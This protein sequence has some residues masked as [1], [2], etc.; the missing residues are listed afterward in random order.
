M[1]YLWALVV[2]LFLIMGSAQGAPF[3]LFNDFFTSTD[4]SVMFVLLVAVWFWGK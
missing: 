3:D 2:V 1:D 4:T